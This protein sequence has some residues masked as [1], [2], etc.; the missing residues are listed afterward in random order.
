MEKY[1]LSKTA[2]GYR[3]KVG[4]RGTKLLR[5]PLY[6]KGTGFT[7]EERKRFDLEGASPDEIDEETRRRL[8]ALGY[9]D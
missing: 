6:N 9:L 8:R 4:M 5:F 7:E 1:E 3:L 2:D